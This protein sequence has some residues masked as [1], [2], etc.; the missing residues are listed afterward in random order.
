MKQNKVLKTKRM[1]LRPM[2]LQELEH[3]QILAPDEDAAQAYGQML[4]C[5]RM[6]PKHFLWY[7]AWALC[8]KTDGAILGDVGF[9]GPARKG[10]VEIGYSLE[11]PYRG[12][13][14]MS[15]AVA[16]MC[17]WALAQPGVYAVTA[18][19]L[20]ENHASQALLQKLR[21]QPD[22]MGEEGPRYRLERHAGSWVPVYLCFGICVGLCLGMSAE[23]LPTGICAGTAVGV[24]IGAAMDLADQQRK[25]RILGEELPDSGKNG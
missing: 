20:P 14:Y 18:E 12:Q 4:C 19:T 6:Y 17:R 23:R 9:K 11:E 13:G 3:R 1:I 7:T 8:R 16:E 22:G 21:F 25:L 24:A 2:T 15:E 5:C 10:T